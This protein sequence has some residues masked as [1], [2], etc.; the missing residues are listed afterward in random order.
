MAAMPAARL[1]V[2]LDLRPRR[3]E[4]RR[5]DRRRPDSRVE[6]V[7][8]VER[9]SEEAAVVARLARPEMARA[10]GGPLKRRPLQAVAAATAG[11]ARQVR[12]AR[13]R[14]LRRRAAPAA[15]AL[16]GPE[17]VPELIILKPLLT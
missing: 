12:L 17:A 11:A 10:A 2:R 8:L 6:P 14:K 13:V 4:E 9:I 5:R 16:A 1:E 7:A 15:P 3:L